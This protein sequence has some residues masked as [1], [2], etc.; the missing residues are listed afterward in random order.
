MLQDAYPYANLLTHFMN[1]KISCEFFTIKV[2]ERCSKTSELLKFFY[3]AI[4]FFSGVYYLTIHQVL[5]HLVNITY[6]LHQFKEDELL[7][8]IVEAMRAK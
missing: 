4:E 7:K 2:W 6:V 5:L 1:L 8:W 3:D